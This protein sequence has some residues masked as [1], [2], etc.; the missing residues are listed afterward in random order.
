MQSMCLRFFRGIDSGTRRN[1]CNV[2]EVI[3]RVL[4]IVDG[5]DQGGS[6]RSTAVGRISLKAK[7][8]S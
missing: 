6:P 4:V 2:G 8:S 1:V 5:G 3:Y 7:N